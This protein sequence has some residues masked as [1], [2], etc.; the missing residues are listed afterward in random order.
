MSCLIVR[1]GRRYERGW[2]GPGVIHDDE[3]GGCG[4]ST[5]K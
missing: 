2:V 5:L 4:L 3:R 1:V